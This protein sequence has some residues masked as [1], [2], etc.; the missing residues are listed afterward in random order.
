[1]N[2]LVVVPQC[3]RRSPGLIRV[4]RLQE[5][6]G[7]LFLVSWPSQQLT[8]IRVVL[9]ACRLPGNALRGSASSM[10]VTWEGR[11][12]P[13]RYGLFMESASVEPPTPCRAFSAIV[14]VGREKR[15]CR[16]VGGSVDTRKDLHVAAVVGELGRILADRN[17][18]ATR[19]RYSRC[20]PGCTSANC[21]S[22]SASSYLTT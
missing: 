14:E 7:Q 13:S 17:V 15:E 18:T 6:P 1:M 11:D 22:V 16:R 3:H 9:R 4:P 19:H 8:A 12:V 10:L 20:S 2:A 21:P 5:C